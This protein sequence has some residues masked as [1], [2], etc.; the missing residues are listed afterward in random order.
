VTQAYLAYHEAKLGARP[1]R[2]DAVAGNG[3]EFRLLD[4]Q[5][6]GVAQEAP[7]LLEYNDTLRVSV[8]VHSRDGRSPVIVIGI[9]RIDGTP[10]YGV[11]TEMD[12]VLPVAESANTFR[13]G[14]EFANL[15]L[16]P[17]SYVVKAHPL[18]PEGVRLFDTIERPLTIRGSSREFGLVRLTHTWVNATASTSV[19]LRGVSG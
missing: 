1:V 9:A 2:T 18:D 11:S 12:G 3:M 6:N 8:S 5:L 10:V 15:A 7:L 4:L 19:R 14:I 17:G 13:V 16:L